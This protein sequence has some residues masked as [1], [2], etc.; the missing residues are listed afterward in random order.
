MKRHG[1]ASRTTS[2][3]SASRHLKRL[4]KPLLTPTLR[5]RGSAVGLRREA[6]KAERRLDQPRKAGTQGSSANPRKLSLNPSSPNRKQKTLA[7]I[8]DLRNVAANAKTSGLT[9]VYERPRRDTG[10]A[11]GPASFP[12][13]RRAAR[14]T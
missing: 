2:S 10:I 3:V 12:T 9:R 6:A 1:S 13:T 7:L 8:E 4:A 5:L 14:S 11:A